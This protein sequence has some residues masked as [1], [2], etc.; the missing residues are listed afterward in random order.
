MHGG[1]QRESNQSRAIKE[2]NLAW[3]QKIGQNGCGYKK[4]SDRDFA[5]A[6]VGAGAGAGQL[7]K[8]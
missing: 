1:H 3:Q 2:E 7:R 4:G 8:I 6:G 5:G